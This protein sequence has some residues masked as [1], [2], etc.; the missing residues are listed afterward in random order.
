MSAEDVAGIAGEYLPAGGVSAG[1]DPGAA[2]GVEGSASAGS[3][4]SAGSEGPGQ[5]DIDPDILLFTGAVIERVLRIAVPQWWT[6]IVPA[7][8]RLTRETIAPL[9]PVTARLVSKYMGW[10]LERFPDEAMFLFMW[11]TVMWPLVASGIPPRKP[12][13]AEKGD[14]DGGGTLASESSSE[15]M[16]DAQG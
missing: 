11:T 15:Q 1:G 9:T 2:A 3:A 5:K 6:D 7:D 4:P 12:K 10:I 8:I 14:D 16:R 13:P